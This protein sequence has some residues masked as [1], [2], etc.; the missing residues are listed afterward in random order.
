MVALIFR[1][2]ATLPGA[3]EWM[4]ETI[5]PAWR[6]GMLQEAAWRIAREATLEPIEPLS[7][8]AL[9]AVGV[10]ES[11]IGEIRAV[12][13][14]YD[15][16]NPENLLT[17]LCLSRLLSGRPASREAIGRPW[18]PPVAPG[19]LAPMGD[20]KSLSPE[21]NELLASVAGPAPPGGKRVVQSLYRHFF[22]RP[23]FL[24]LVVKSLRPR[25]E[26]GSVDA[27]AARIHADMS[28]AAD[29]IVSTLRASPAPDPGI[30]PACSRFAGGIIPRMV[31]VGRLLQTAIPH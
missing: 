5:S 28:R 27:A 2:L 31:V 12:I 19:P 11:G 16:A 1:H 13:E 18:T 10:D 6:T 15:R 14:S 21:M 20:L 22:H 25:I 3:L 29:E 4:W 9:A 24:A 17:V 26:D 7:R 23:A 30:E 8:P